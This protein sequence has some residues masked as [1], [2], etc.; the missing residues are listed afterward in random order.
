MR[1]EAEEGERAAGRRR[2]R[3]E[4]ERDKVSRRTTDGSARAAVMGGLCLG[5]VFM[6]VWLPLIFGTL[7]KPA[8]Q[9]I[10]APPG[11]VN[12]GTAWIP[13]SLMHRAPYC[14]HPCDDHHTGCNQLQHEWIC[15]VGSEGRAEEDNTIPVCWALLT[16]IHLPPSRS[17]AI[18][19]W[20]FHRWNS[21]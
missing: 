21:W 12:F 20:V 5:P 10:N 1:G 3:R 14:G 17:G 18:F 7:T 8:V 9:P 13:P 16:W 6:A 19:E 2:G 11:K 15:T 4:G